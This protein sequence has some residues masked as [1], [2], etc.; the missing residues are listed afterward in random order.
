MTTK[1]THT[2]ATTALPENITVL[3]FFKACGIE[4]Q[5]SKA[6]FT[7]DLGMQANLIG[8]SR[9]C[10]MAAQGRAR[11]LTFKYNLKG[12]GPFR[13]LRRRYLKFRF[14]HSAFHNRVMSTQDAIAFLANVR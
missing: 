1:K 12:F 2:T 8:G 10:A 7:D 6:A 11:G 3:E 13:S 4:V 14:I 9:L 5:D